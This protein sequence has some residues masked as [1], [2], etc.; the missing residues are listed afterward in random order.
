MGTTLN[1]ED[2]ACDGCE[3]NVEEAIRGVAGVTG[4]DADHES[5]T[6]VVEGD[7]DAEALV[8]AVDDAGYEAS[9]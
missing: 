5:G 1:V 4:V 7:A 6:V 9:A 3:A 8:A 2:M